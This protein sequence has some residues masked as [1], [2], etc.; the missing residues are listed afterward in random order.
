[1]PNALR[2]AKPARRPP[3]ISHDAN[4]IHV[5]SWY[6]EPEQEPLA[7][8]LLV[9]ITLLAWTPLIALWLLVWK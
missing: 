5:Q 6:H 2:Y 7:G 3:N 9:S 4:V 1:M 8:S